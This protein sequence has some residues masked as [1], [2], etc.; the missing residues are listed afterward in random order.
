MLAGRRRLHT[1]RPRTP[2]VQILSNGHYAVMVNAAGAGSSRCNNLAVTRS[3][4]DPTCDNGGQAVF[5]RDCD[6]GAVW[7]CGFQ[8]TAVVPDAYRVTFTE[9]RVEILRRDG[10]WATRLQ[11]LVSAEH[12]AE[13]RRVS[14][15]NQS[16]RSREVEVTSYAEIVLT[17]AAADRAHRAFSNLFVQTHLRA[18]AGDAPGRAAAA[19]LR[20]CRRLGCAPRGDRGHGGR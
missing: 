19:L 11:V 10:P 3:L 7:S 13:A 16:D 9:D 14:I 20:G 4:E 5:L 12:D 2:H 1:W 18:A 15:S 8:P 6:S 17:T